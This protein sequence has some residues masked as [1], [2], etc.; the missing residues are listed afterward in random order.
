MLIPRLRPITQ[1]RL[2][3]IKKGRNSA[4][5]REWRDYCL[6]R[7]E[8]KCQ[9]PNCIRNT[10]LQVHHIKKFSTRR[11]LRTD[12]MNGVTLCETCHRKLAACEDRYAFM[13]LKIAYA[14]EQVYRKKLNES[15]S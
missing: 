9:F 10:K 12:T 15:T 2:A 4:D 14:N 6:S 1:K 11:D 8:Y 3:D 5:Y 7:D 13:F